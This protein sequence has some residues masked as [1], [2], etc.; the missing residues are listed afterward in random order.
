MKA[1]R[2]G[3]PIYPVAFE[4]DAMLECYRSTIGA[5]PSPLGRRAHLALPASAHT[6]PC[7]AGWHTG[8]DAAV[9]SLSIVQLATAA[10]RPPR[11]ASLRGGFASL[12]PAATPLDLG[13]CEK[14]E[15]DQQPEPRPKSGS[16]YASKE[17]ASSSSTRQ[18]PVRVA[19]A[20]VRADSERAIVI[21]Q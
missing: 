17:P 10:S 21:S 14:G 6:G 5:R 18:A 4:P 20:Q 12:D 13:G 2:E 11:R 8:I 7:P 15:E 1:L 3:S 19:Q 16:F 9:F